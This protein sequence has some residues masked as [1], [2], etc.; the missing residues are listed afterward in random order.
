M[1]KVHGAVLSQAMETSN[2]SI[3]S[4]PDISSG[5][6]SHKSSDNSRHRRK[7]SHIIIDIVTPTLSRAPSAQHERA[8]LVEASSIQ[9][10]DECVRLVNIAFQTSQAF[11]SLM[12][13]CGDI[14]QHL[15]NE[16]F[17][18]YPGQYFHIIIGQNNAFGFAIDD[19][20]YF[21]EI[22]QEQY[23]VL[24]FSTSF[25]KKVNLERHDANSLMILQWKSLVGKRSKK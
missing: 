23:R 10:G 5:S 17:K 9:F 11:P 16:L 21:A 2:L 20:E 25:D 18:K 19:D 4:N 3:N 6:S 15:R 22:E 12:S 1:D 8:I 24:I 7:K 13:T 14:S